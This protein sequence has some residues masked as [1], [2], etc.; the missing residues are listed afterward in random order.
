[1]PITNKI[2]QYLHLV[3]ALVPVLVALCVVALTAV[4]WFTYHL[5]F[6]RGRSFEI[7]SLYDLFTHDNVIRGIII[8]LAAA[9]IVVLIG[10]KK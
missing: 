3:K 8:V 9:V 2:G 5:Y 7:H 1:M 4:G 10:K 6:A